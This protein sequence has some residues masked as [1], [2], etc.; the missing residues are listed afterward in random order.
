MAAD[1]TDEPDS[2]FCKDSVPDTIETKDYCVYNGIK[3]EQ[4]AHVCQGPYDYVCNNG[5][6]IF[7]GPCP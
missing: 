2:P 4:G 7:A 5:L 3:Y 1:S 6:W